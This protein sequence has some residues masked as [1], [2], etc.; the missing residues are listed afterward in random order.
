VLPVGVL[1]SQPAQVLHLS[2]LVILY[3]A[4]VIICVNVLLRCALAV[5]T[6][7]PPGPGN[8]ASIAATP[9]F[10]V[11]LSGTVH[12]VKLTCRPQPQVLQYLGDPF[13]CKATV[14]KVVL[15]VSGCS[16]PLFGNAK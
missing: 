3:H 11:Y 1:T 14:C 12:K 2:E 10:F 16:S 4:Q 6:I 7:E 13:F 9:K 15:H 8:S 5:L